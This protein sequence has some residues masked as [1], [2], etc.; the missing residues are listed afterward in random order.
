MT[1]GTISAEG[2]EAAAEAVS[3]LGLLL[4]EVRASR[5]FSLPA[6]PVARQDLAVVFQNVASLVRAGMPIERAL[7][8]SESLVHGPLREALGDVRRRLR[9]GEGV[10]KALEASGEVF[11]R[12]IVGMVHAGERSSR[13]A[14]ALDGVS[15]QLEEEAAL[16]A[17]IRSALAYPALILVVG[18]ASVIIM[19]G[20]VVPRFAE[21]LSELGAELPASTR[22][23]LLASELLRRFGLIGA[24]GGVVAASAAS[25]LMRRPH[26]RRRVDHALLRLPVLGGIRLGFA[27]ART[28]R[29]LGAM[30]STGMPLLSA[31]D[32]ARD[33]AGDAEVA[34]RLGR[35]RDAVARGERLTPSMESEGALT[36]LALQLVGVGESS[37]DLG[38][39]VTR[40]GDLAS[41]R[42]Q[43]SLR[44][45][46]SLVEPALVIAMGFLVA[47]TAG[48]LLQAVY[49]VRPGV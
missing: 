20:I 11:P 30:L 35:V 44:G 7:A 37:G 24:A 48:A 10:A 32:S 31:L 41:E 15:S 6:R 2:R 22:G 28:C 47:M 17:Q 43:R 12:V 34:E 13:L 16:R 23:L 19:G 29:A 45:L 14:D 38:R 27:S 26:V 18:V 9:E 42:T 49:S 3:R 39:M 1:Q 5:G 36:P 46:V 25:A 33:A 4:L 21:V 8:A 40:A